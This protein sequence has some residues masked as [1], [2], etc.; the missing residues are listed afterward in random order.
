[1][2]SSANQQP[3]VDEQLMEEFWRKDSEE[4]YNY[5]STLNDNPNENKIL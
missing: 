3:I 5:L 1:M 2:K 4:F